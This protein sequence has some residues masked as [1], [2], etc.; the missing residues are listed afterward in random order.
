[1]QKYHTVLFF[2]LIILLDSAFTATR[3][4]I[5]DEPTARKG[6]GIWLF[7]FL[8]S[9]F[10][11]LII[12]DEYEKYLRASKSSSCIQKVVEELLTMCRDMDDLTQSR[13][14]TYKYFFSNIISLLACIAIYQLPSSQIEQANSPLRSRR[15]FYRLQLLIIRRRLEHLHCVLYPCSVYLLLL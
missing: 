13:A 3:Y 15:R 7:S 5:L 14:T 12:Q 2:L 11:F 4:E 1:M 9:Y 10:L 6:K 8:G